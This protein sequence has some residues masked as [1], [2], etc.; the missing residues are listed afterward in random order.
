MGGGGGTRCMLVGKREELLAEGVR[1]RTGDF[2][3][4]ATREV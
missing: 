3:P 2:T 4:E 1:V